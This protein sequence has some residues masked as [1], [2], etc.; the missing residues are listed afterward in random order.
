M[1]GKHICGRGVL[2]WRVSSVYILPP[3]PPDLQRSIGDQKKK[4]KFS[5]SR[6]WSL[7]SKSRTP[8]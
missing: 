5:L 7:R 2:R 1:G 4:S 3:T 6:V 8:E